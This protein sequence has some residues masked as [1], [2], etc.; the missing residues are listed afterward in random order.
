MKKT[1]L[2]T[3]FTLGALFAFQ[4]TVLLQKTIYL[5]RAQDAATT[6][7]NA[8]TN[9]P[10]PTLM[11]TYSSTESGKLTSGSTAESKVIISVSTYN[12][13]SLITPTITVTPTPS[14]SKNK[15]DSAGTGFGGST[16]TAAA[17]STPTPLPTL[18]P[19]SK[20][21][22]QTF[23]GTYTV[24]PTVTPIPVVY[25][26]TATP[27]PAIKITL[28]PTPILPDSLTTETE[29]T[30]EKT[31]AI[32]DT[33]TLAEIKIIPNTAV[34]TSGPTEKPLLPQEEQ[35]LAE[36]NSTSPGGILITLEEKKGTTFTTRQ[37]ELTVKKGD[38]LFTI[39]NKP[40]E[41]MDS[42]TSSVTASPSTTATASRL[43]INANNVIA[44]LSMG[45]SVDPLSGILT[46]DTPTGPQRVSIMPDEALGIVIELNALN[47]KQ[48]AGQQSI[49]LANEDGKLV[50]QISG[51][52]VEKFLGLFPL[53]IQK[54][55][56]VSVDTGSIV[57]VKLSAWS[58]FLSVFT[59]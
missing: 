34:A 55:I 7:T 57:K 15:P 16:N 18:T 23:A 31:T 49:F 40:E 3:L 4:Q 19:T 41:N 53:P 39:S 24:S 45:V 37:D 17:T 6:Q 47:A 56:V 22:P 38:Q 25:A 5:V 10:I 35:L 1:W 20:P 11:E 42:K 32:L 36:N 28:T 43:E 27:V 21:T 51:E 52:K 58:Q 50:Y 2:V 46:V 8:I 30:V 13:D 29:K 59:F 44:Q 54:Q 9:T 33:T 48:T 12:P 26:P 14:G